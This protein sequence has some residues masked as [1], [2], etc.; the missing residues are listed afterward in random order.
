[1]AE[2]GHVNIEIAN[3]ID[4]GAGKRDLLLGLAQCGGDRTCVTCID[5]TARK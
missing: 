2:R 4:E 5:L 1:M 3:R